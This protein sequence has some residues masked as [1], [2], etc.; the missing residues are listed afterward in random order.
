MSERQ[1][2]CGSV[3]SR[4]SRCDAGRWAAG[5][6]FLCLL[7]A[8]SGST[9]VVG[10]IDPD[11][12]DVVS[13][14]RGSSSAP[15]SNG[16]SEQLNPAGLAGFGQNDDDASELLVVAGLPLRAYPGPIF[17]WPLGLR[18][19]AFFAE[20]S[21]GRAGPPD[22]IER[23]VFERMGAFYSEQRKDQVRFVASSGDVAERL[24]AL[25]DEAR[26]FFGVEP[27]SLVTRDA[28]SDEYVVVLGTASC[29]QLSNHHGDPCADPSFTDAN[30]NDGNSNGSNA[31]SGSSAASFD[32]P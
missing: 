10:V 25:F 29:E 2:A 15:G 13:G 1:S 27:R 11:L 32:A 26:L 12:T 31:W 4:S 3:P 8:C 23:E 21:W 30:S 6:A 28:W 24:R 5:C 16:E 9:D 20:P 22:H 18:L 14:V 7:C 17:E 19:R